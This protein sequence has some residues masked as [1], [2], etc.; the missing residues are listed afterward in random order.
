MIIFKL[1]A[2]QEMFINIYVL[3]IYD[4]K[5]INIHELKRLLSDRSKLNCRYFLEFW[6][7]VSLEYKNITK[8][9]FPT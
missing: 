9:M 7:K 8:M 5:F 3:F 1:H 6:I 4:Q 2:N